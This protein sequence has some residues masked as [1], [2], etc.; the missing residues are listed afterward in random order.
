[1]RR[2]ALIIRFFTVL[3]LALWLSGVATYSARAQD[4]GTPPAEEVPTEEPTQ[5]PTEEPA[6]LQGLLTIYVFTCTDGPEGVVGELLLEGEFTPSENC[7]ESGE[8]AISIGGGS[9]EAVTSGAQYTLD[10][11]DY[12]VDEV[13]LGKSATV[14]IA[15]QVPVIVYAVFYDQPQS[16]AGVEEDG[17]VSI[18]KHICPEAIQTDEEFNAIGDYYAKIQTCLAITL[19]NDPGP[20][21]SKNGNDFANQLSFDF[22]VTFGGGN[23]PLQIDAATFTPDELCESTLGADIN[24]NIEDD[25]CLD[26]SNYAYSGVT[27]G[28]VTVTETTPPS[29]YRY[30]AVEFVPESGD[31]AALVSSTVETGEI[32]L[33]TTS[34]DNVVLHVFNFQE[35]IFN[36]VTI[37]KHECP[38]EI[39]T[40]ADFDDLGDF[41]DKALTCLVIT[42]DDDFGPDG[43]LNGINRTFDF[44]VEGSDG[45]VQKFA[46]TTF[47]PGQICESQLGLDLNG[48]P[49]DDLCF[50]TSGYRFDNVLQGAG[51]LIT[52]TKAPRGFTYGA[53][54]F[55]PDSGDDAALV[56]ASDDG[57]IELDTTD[58][59]NVTLHIFNFKTPAEPTPE[60]SDSGILQ[61][62]NFYCIG[63]AEETVIFSLAPGADATSDDL[64]DESCYAGDAD[65]EI[66]VFGADSTVESLSVDSSGM[67]VVSDLPVTDGSTGPHLITELYSGESTDF[68]IDPETVTRV[69]VLNYEV[70]ET[71]E[72]DEVEEI[73]EDDYE[74]EE[75]IVS[76]EDLAETGFGPV[77]TPVDGGMV[78]MLS[79][80]SI[81][82][83]AGAAGFRRRVR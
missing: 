48:I 2:A 60:P 43:A 19:P 83:L 41:Y 76:G 31:D 33:D 46:D 21:G 22:G 6:L 17:T 56:D 63:D 25:L 61:V 66:L 78:F 18:I 58:D 36:R 12:A 77:G 5:E 30:G 69:I 71:D 55:L 81:L 65:F 70:E 40:T 79:A 51:V 75:N 82:V 42:R 38:S 49:E 10:E 37:V 53:L 15:E 27:Q 52:E 68:D 8:A 13:N 62:L 3:S 54:E 26:V 59:G 45:E 28:S 39:E 14:S 20:D 44:S 74:D 34:D 11:G 57:V 4:E 32:E 23:S 16:E 72:E 35:P 47:V 24:N 9:T 29:G 1:M 73:Y 50:G 67:T 64:G 80:M 7:T